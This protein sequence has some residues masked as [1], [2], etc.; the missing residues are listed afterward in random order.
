MKHIIL[1]TLMIMSTYSYTQIV[2]PKSDSQ[3]KIA[4][5][6]VSEVEESVPTKSGYFLF[7]LDGVLRYPARNE[8]YPIIAGRKLMIKNLKK[9]DKVLFLTQ[10]GRIEKEVNAS[11]WELRLK[12]FEEQFYFAPEYQ[13]LSRKES[14]AMAKA[15]LIQKTK[16]QEAN[17]M[18]AFETQFRKITDH[19]VLIPSAEFLYGRQQIDMQAFEIS[20][21]EITKSQYAFY[22]SHKAEEKRKEKSPIKSIIIDPDPRIAIPKV[23]RSDIDWT[24][25][26]I[27]TSSDPLS[28]PN[29]PV[30]FVTWHEATAFCEWLSQIDT[31]YN[32]RLPYDYEWD[33]A[34]S[35]GFTSQYPWPSTIG[36]DEISQYGNFADISLK[37]SINYSKSGVYEYWHDSAPFKSD[38]G[39]Y[40]P[41]D[42]GLYDMGGN[43]AEWTSIRDTDDGTKH[44]IKGGSF[45][46]RHI[47]S[48]VDPQGKSNFFAS[49]KRHYG[50]GFRLVRVG[51]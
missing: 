7:D 31:D 42:M 14:D 22:K 21:Y 44:E 11:G 51:K 13:E 39:Q 5:K 46:S 2:L 25:N 30:S 16:E 10:D 33:Y 12:D 6:K 15:S 18:K 41:N 48:K 3:K 23:E 34:A 29:E 20:A 32:Y 1:A 45:F 9:E 38:V 26:E 47:T 27:N 40:K 36:Q 49:D 37:K 24:S 50:I 35:A 19:F 8:E 43:V 28:D 4:S 17:T